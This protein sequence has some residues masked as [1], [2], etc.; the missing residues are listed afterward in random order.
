MVLSNGRHSIRSPA[1]GEPRLSLLRHK[2][3][4]ASLSAAPAGLFCR[5]LAGRHALNLRDVE[6]QEFSR[7][8]A[9]EEWTTSAHMLPAGIVGIS[10]DRQAAGSSGVV[11]MSRDRKLHL[12]AF[13]RPVSLHTGARRYPGAYPTLMTPCR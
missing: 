6:E 9:G 12:G 4:K 10:D 5:W 3:S 7:Y 11:L 1:E 2:D 8:R 13:M